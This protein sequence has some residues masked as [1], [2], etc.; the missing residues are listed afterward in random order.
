[1]SMRRLTTLALLNLCGGCTWF[2]NEEYVL[3][4]SDP[5]GAR[6]LVDGVD[7]GL[8]TPAN[9]SLGDIL[10]G[11]H[12]IRLEKKGYRPEQ[13][14]LVQYTETYTSKWIDGAYEDV[15]PPLPLF[16]TAGDFV[17]PFAVR[18]AIVPGELHCRLYGEDEP[19]LGFDLLQQGRGSTPMRQP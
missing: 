4:T 19:L 12:A 1:M 14:L 16:W 7:T 9:L 17:F 6:I 10:G 15:L 8:T 5:L 18:A 3:V 13:R 2:H 11:N